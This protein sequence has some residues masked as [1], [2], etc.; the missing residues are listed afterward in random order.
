MAITTHTACSAESEETAAQLS[1]FTARGFAAITTALHE[2]AS[3]ED[4]VAGF[5]EDDEHD[6]TRAQD[7][8]VDAWCRVEAAT[9]HFLRVHPAEPQA[10]VETAERIEAMLTLY[11]LQERGEVFELVSDTMLVRTRVEAGSQSDGLLGA[12]IPWMY[13]AA[14]AHA[15][16][17][18][19]DGDARDLDLDD[20][21]AEAG[22][23]DV[24]VA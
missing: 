4:V 14:M 21:P 9:S 10:L 20:V 12:I 19:D 15:V 17:L 7:A 5:A 16:F 2:A 1:P 6:L 24:L 11:G 22:P 18:P 8:T 23:D 13:R 3:C